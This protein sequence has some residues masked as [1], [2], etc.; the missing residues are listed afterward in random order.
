MAFIFVSFELSKRLP[1]KPKFFTAELEAIMPVLCY[2][3][4]TAKS[5]KFVIFVT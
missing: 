3:R 5:N 2:I 4:S 1:D